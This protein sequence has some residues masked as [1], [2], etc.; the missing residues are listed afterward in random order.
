M[1]RE[2][3]EQGSTID[4]SAKNNQGSDQSILLLRVGVL[5]KGNAVLARLSCGGSFLYNIYE[6]KKKVTGTENCFVCIYLSILIC[7]FLSIFRC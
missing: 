4:D 6:K 2:V 7:L 5:Q 1:T 3:N